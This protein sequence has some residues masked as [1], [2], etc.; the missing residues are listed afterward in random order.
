MTL[1]LY[2]WKMR[3]CVVWMKAKPQLTR[4]AGAVNLALGIMLLWLG[5][6]VLR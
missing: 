1:L 4:A 6:A 3:Q 2:P 5:A